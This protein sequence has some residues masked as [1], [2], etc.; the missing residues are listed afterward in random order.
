MQDKE[1][2][3]LLVTA[4]RALDGELQH[5]AE[6]GESLKREAF[7]TQKSVDRGAQTLRQVAE[8]EGRLGRALTDLV[9]AIGDV[10]DCQAAQAELIGER[11]RAL[12]AR[13][14]LLR[15]LLARYEALGEIAAQ[16]SSAL[17]GLPKR[18]PIENGEETAGALPGLI[19]SVTRAAT[20][21]ETLAADAHEKGFPDVGR[22]V[23]GLRQQI[24]AAQNKMALLL[25]KLRPGAGNDPHSEAAESS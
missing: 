21:A 10:R 15:E 17:S 12:E 1:E 14:L 8:C 4:A 7:S 16:V 20:A 5:F 22:N 6:L 25:A 24:L 11:A 19:E 23:E 2:S 9:R 13:G 3:S 18:A